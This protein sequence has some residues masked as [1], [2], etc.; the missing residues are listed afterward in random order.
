MSTTYKVISDR[1]LIKFI[2]AVNEH[3][4]KGWELQGG[5]SSR[6]TKHIQALTL[7]KRYTE[8]ES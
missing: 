8:K 5:V 6:D 2:D 4:E 3:L 1:N 7:T